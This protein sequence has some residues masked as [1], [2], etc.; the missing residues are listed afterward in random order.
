[1][2]ADVTQLQDMPISQL[3]DPQPE[4]EL[5]ARSDQEEA[6]EVDTDKPGAMADR[7]VDGSKAQRG[8]RPA[9]DCGSL[10]RSC[11]QSAVGLLRDP[12]EHGQR[13]VRRVEILLGLLGEDAGDI[14]KASF[15]RA[16]Q[17]RLHH[18]L[19]RQ[20]ESCVLGR[21]DWVAQEASNPDAL[22]EAGTFRHTLWKRVQGVVT[23]LLASMVA[24]IDRDSNLELLAT[25]NTRAWV[26]ELWMFIFNDI[27]LLSIPLVTNDARS[28]SDRAHILV[29]SYAQRPG[30][31]C[32]AVPFSWRIRDY[33]E[34]LWVQAQ[35]ISAAA[36][37]GPGPAGKL[38]EIF[39][40]TP[41]GCFLAGLPAEA[42]RELL[43][44]YLR[45]FLLL[46]MQVSTEPALELLQM[47]LWSCIQQL[48]AGSP[49]EPSLPWVHRAYQHFRIRLQNF[50]RILTIHPP[51]LHSL[52]TA[53]QSQDPAGPEMVLDVW[54][55]MACT[56]LL[57][58]DLLK[59]SPQ[60]WLR[61]VKSLAVPV[62]LL[63]SE[64]YVQAP[65]GRAGDLIREVRGP[66]T[67]IFSVALFVEHVLLGTEDHS[68]ELRALVTDC[69]FSLDKCLQGNSDIKTLPPFL[70]VMT[71]LCECKDR[72][73]RTFA[74][75]GIQP[76]PVCLVDPRSPVCLPCDHVFC[77]DCVK[78]SLTMG[79][80]ACPLCL[81]E[82]PDGFS[83]TVSQEMSDAIE[84]HARFRRLCIGFFVDLV[85]TLCFKDNCPPSRDVVQALLAL[86]FT[87]KTLLRDPP[88]SHTKSLSPFDDV[89]DK[90]PVIRSVVLKLLLKYSFPA[91][92]DHIQDYL[93]RLE[94]KPFL[95]KD[96][97]ELYVLFSSCLEDSIQERSSALP[98][99]DEATGLREDGQFLEA[100]LLRGRR[101]DLAPEASVEYLQEMAQIRLCLDRACEV[102]SELQGD[103]AP[104][105]AR[106]R[107]LQ[108]VER[109]CT[110][111]ENDWYRVYLVR[112]LASRQGL[113]FVQS[114]LQAGHPAQWVFPHEVLAQQEDLLGQMDRFLVHG[115][116]YKA[117]RDAVGKAVLESKPSTIGAALGACRGSQA[118]QATYLLLAL[119]REVAMLYQ[120]RNT[121]L[122][123]KREQLEALCKSIE[124][125][126]VLSSD[127]R[128]FATALVTNSLP[129]LR[130]VGPGHGGLAGTLA[131]LAVHAA[132]TLLCG[133]HRV[134][135]P[136]RNLAFS[137]ATM[138]AAFLPTMPE[139]MLAQARRWQG[140]ETVR[141]YRC[142]RGHLCAVG[143]CGRPMQ[144]SVCIDCGAPVGGQNHR[145]ITGF[146]DAQNDVDRTQTGHV[147]GSPA[148]GEEAVA[149]DRELA[150][151]AFLL[152]RLLTHLAMLWGAAHSP[153]E[154]TL[155]VKPAVRDPGAFLQQHLQRD[156]RQLMRTLGKSAD[157]TVQVVHLVLCVLLREQHPLSGQGSFSF[158]A[159]LST[160][161][162]RNSWEKLLQALVLPEL[163]RLDKT[164]LEVNGLISRDE[165]I[166]SNPVARIVL[167]DPAAFLRRLPRA[168][169]L[170]CSRTWSCRARLT[171]EHL[172]HV[173]EQKNG[174]EGVPVLWRF[175]QKEAELRLVKFLP[176][177]LALQR[178]L[179]KWFQNVPEAEFQ[180]IR[181]FID[182]HDSGGLKQLLLSRVTLFLSTWNKLRRSLETQGEI[183][184]PA[185]YCRADLDLD[186]D[187]EVILPRRQGLGLCATALVSYLIGLH[188]DMVSAVQRLSKEEPSYSV[189]A[190]EVADLHVV[191]YEAERD[192]MPLILANCQYQVA[193]G[194]ESLQ[195]LDLERIQRQVTGR[196]LQGKP[197]LTLRGLPTLV[198]RRDW[199]YEH[200]FA[201]IRS[202]VPQSPLPH[203]AASALGG[204]LQ[205]YSDACEAL[206]L[207]EVTLGFLSTAG[208][209]PDMDLTLY[210]QDKL[211]MGDQTEQVAKALHLHP[212]RLRHVIALWQLLS[213]HKSE[214][215]LRLQKEPF[216]E[217]SAKYQE[218]LSPGS[219][220]HLHAFLNQSSLDVFLLE[221]HEMILLKLKNPH[222]EADFRP[223]WSLRDTLV[224]YME[225]KE[226]DIPPEMEGQFPEEILLC[227]CVSAWKTA[228]V[229]KRAR[230]TR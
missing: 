20:E 108:Q 158:N 90:T 162:Q 216:R 143:E 196:F 169:A 203:A 9:L 26:R 127:V 114:F 41:L 149:S 36:G 167:G 213:A 43:L 106:R 70:A 225:T 187:F 144:Q 19:L 170:H 168:S 53:A 126:Q 223:D 7:E 62:E 157:D 96:K 68:P 136:L 93:S 34:E 87:E 195:E 152:A 142:P 145:S 154:L 37:P 121:R 123:P 2:V 209:D 30:E 166:S 133:R 58:R 193:Q 214:H 147:L 160:K 204:Q 115:L 100:C 173:V 137:P 175:L 140:L 124:E 176:E 45:D 85:S 91:V 227:H 21:K 4:E 86:L 13:N 183:K 208:E 205:S 116:E 117:V 60:A 178:D 163:E 25:P 228:A 63:C 220:K 81:T 188:N 52:A 181:G 164:L 27:N 132:A 125:S 206:S 159:T 38:E 50:S 184:L 46:T 49:E 104:A 129:L 141:W 146:T 198:Y 139:D 42:R 75:F 189:D 79:Q 182:S 39:L 192:L 14:G 201:A 172:R 12:G 56:E 229:L 186:S 80:M 207:V 11:I 101:R 119:F 94:R 5:E 99:R 191:S 151:A 65:A 22:Q 76:C 212:C 61:A 8:H 110:Q 153:Q 211:R 74:R 224:S 107:F 135:E 71:V 165:R 64:G 148:T 217:I 222:T 131:E 112:R 190:S 83:P 226:G 177:I 18:L 122:H 113:E 102:L 33:V 82:L 219:A 215:L 77:Q 24:I 92:K 16:A 103:S 197:R 57:T 66:W 35:Y 194:G 230:Q 6:M 105:E 73:S 59:P 134:L 67:R 44:F 179:V 120:A 185:D 130:T 15:A 23:P 69:V 156:L 218:R 97:T 78:Q 72:A 31:A 55:A 54:A 138:V 89:V 1:M 111:S 10:L 199:N 221:L 40:Q 29:Q 202:R 161:E 180:S 98:A 95:D 150:P 88:Q 118:H 128:P 17:V 109:F 171:V 155:L 51:V 28:N 3:F 47:A 200:L 32:S 84:R 174:R 48:R 210:L